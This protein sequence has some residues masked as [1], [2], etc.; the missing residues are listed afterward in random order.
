MFSVIIQF[1]FINFPFIKYACKVHSNCR[2]EGFPLFHDRKRYYHKYIL[3][4]IKYL[5]TKYIAP[6]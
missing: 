6:K 3:M 2:L 1:K 4:I 5:N